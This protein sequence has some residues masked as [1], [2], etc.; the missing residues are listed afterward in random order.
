LTRAL[1]SRAE[2]DPSDA[3]VEA[4]PPALGQG[5]PWYAGPKRPAPLRDHFVA[6]VGRGYA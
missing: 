5:M 2:P 3:V 6:R 1:V 4:R